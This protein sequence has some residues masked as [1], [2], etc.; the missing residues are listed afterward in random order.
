MRLLLVGWDAQ[1]RSLSRIAAKALDV[2]FGNANDVC[3][4]ADNESLLYPASL[5]TFNP[6][7]I[8][9]SIPRE[10]IEE[11]ILPLVAQAKEKNI[12]Y[13]FY[14][15]FLHRLNH[16]NQTKAYGQCKAIMVQ[17][18]QNC[19]NDDKRDGKPVIKQVTNE[20]SV[21]RYIAAILAKK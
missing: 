14:T 6:D 11:R 7:V 4:I 2:N 12:P 19:V 13:V 18:G 15:S 17:E 10:K 8:L 20:M 3:L 9:I 21:I 1:V 5:V 16:I